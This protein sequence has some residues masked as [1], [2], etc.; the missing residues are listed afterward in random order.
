MKKLLH[1]FCVA[2]TLAS[3]CA[4]QEE[5]RNT[6]ELVDPWL[7][8][9]TPVDV[10]LEKQVGAATISSDWRHDDMGSVTV[11]LVTGGLDLHKVKVESLSFKYPQSQYCPTCSIKPGDTVDLSSG[12]A[13]FM[14][15]AYNGETREYVITFTEFL[16]PLVGT[17]GHDPVA[18]ILDGSAPTSS[19]LIIG[20]WPGQIVMST[21]MDKSWHWGGGYTTAD[22]EDNVVSFMLTEVDSATGET[23]GT[24]VNYAGADGKSANYSYNNTYDVNPYYRIIPVGSSR[25][26]KDVDGVLYIYDKDDTA[27]ATPLYII[28]QLSAGSY[29]Y[30]GKTFNV[31]NMAWARTFTH[32]DDE[33]VVDNNWPDTRWMVD[34]IRATIW[35]MKRLSDQPAADH[36]EQF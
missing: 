4:C 23:Y 25:W 33:W 11:Q 14:V 3:I 1:F 29:T 28:N 12:S 31:G 6:A 15:T 8:E 21:A 22:E 27:Y 35:T 18:G 32:S 5:P 24:I 16:D 10:R 19:M 30:E 34:N 9:R 17:Y 20:G 2:A 7:R 36:N 13:S 26:K